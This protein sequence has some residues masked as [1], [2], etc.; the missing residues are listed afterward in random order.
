[1]GLEVT[2][3]RS[4]PHPLA[5]LARH[6]IRTVLDIGANR[7]QFAREAL[8]LFPMAAIHSFEPLPGIFEELQAASR[9]QSRWKAH[10]FALGAETGWSTIHVNDFSAASSLLSLT[11]LATQAFPHVSQTQTATIRVERLDD[12]FAQ[13]QLAHN[14][15]VKM[16]V[17]GFEDRVIRGGRATLEQA[18]VLLMEVSFV[19]LYEGQLLFDD[20]HG[21]AKELGF[22]CAGVLGETRDPANGRLLYAD[23]IYVARKLGL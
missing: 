14:L 9:A 2:R 4:V 7:G 8:T 19:P 6:E 21:L 16:D 17:Q 15:F 1:M 22:R 18:A 3:K 12:W 23:A 10:R 20:L 13:Q 11:P 5:F